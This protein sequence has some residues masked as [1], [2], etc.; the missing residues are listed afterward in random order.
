MVIG[1]YFGEQ[2]SSSYFLSIIVF[3]LLTIAYTIKGGLRSSLLTDMIQ[4]VLFIVML[5]AILAVILPQEDVTVSRIVTSGEWTAIGGI[6]LLFVALLQI[7]SYPFHDPVM[8][9][10][11]FILS[12]IHI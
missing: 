9:D 1:S 8:T 5:F 2:G 12:L 10:R 7:F 3:T 4:M 6:N 11:A